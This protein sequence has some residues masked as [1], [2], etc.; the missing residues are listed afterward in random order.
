MV[1][2]YDGPA[3]DRFALPLRMHNLLLA[4]AGRLD[5][6]GLNDIREL[7]ARA[8]LDEAAEL[9][10]GILIAGRLPVRAAEQRE[11]AL[12]LELSRSDATL[13]DQLTVSDDSSA[14]DVVHR[15]SGDDQPER[16]IAAALS[17]PLRVLPDL[18]SVHAVWRN[19][20]AGAVG[21]ALPQRVVLVEVGP[22]G[23]PPATAHRLETALRRAGI[24]AAVEVMDTETARGAYHQQ[25][26]AA[27]VLVWQSEARDA[28][29]IEA[30]TAVPSAEVA[31][32]APAEVRSA[33]S[34]PA[35]VTPAEAAGVPAAEVP[36]ETAEQ[37]EVPAPVQPAEQ[38]VQPAEQ[39]EEPAEQTV[40]PAEQT[41]QPAEQMP[42]DPPT[43]TAAVGP[44]H[45]PVPRTSTP[46]AEKTTVFAPETPAAAR[47]PDPRTA[48]DVPAAHTGGALDQADASDVEPLAP[49]EMFQPLTDP[50]DQDYSS[51]TSRSEHTAD[52]SAEVARVR[53]SV[54][55]D[56][57]PATASTAGELD[58]SA[59]PSGS[60]DDP[61]LSE[62]DRALLRE[63]HAE[64]A[65][66]EREEASKVPLNGRERGD[67]PPWARFGRA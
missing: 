22:D 31:S 4:L 66:R 21:G 37:T 24:R 64:L 16:G 1:E 34:T 30:P 44:E 46:S 27:A 40:Q 10:V 2:V 5:D 8:R 51:S 25:A 49:G 67:D 36:A 35:E 14:I 43:S 50:Q 59:T 7:T 54:F 23:S 39:T 17:R 11:L 12:V 63:L 48:T 56:A 13:A 60:L 18:R 19:T 58:P 47:E 41:E 33:E 55:K 6:S 65:K 15:F 53:A 20:P 32:L 61:R 3:T 42:V 29:V 62:R 52:L 28:R 57:E 38:P 26:H 9:T 45:Q